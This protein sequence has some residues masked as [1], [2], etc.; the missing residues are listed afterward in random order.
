MDPSKQATGNSRHR[1]LRKVLRRY[2]LDQRAL[3]RLR[4]NSK[5]DLTRP[6]NRCLD[7][8]AVWRQPT[9]A[10]H[11]LIE[12]VGDGASQ[13]NFRPLGR[14]AR[15]ETAAKPNFV[16]LRADRLVSSGA[17]GAGCGLESLLLLRAKMFAVVVRLSVRG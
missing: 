8:R 5:L 3:A 10:P 12:G 16:L 11:C 14:L 7:I 1:S 2:R 15:H 9:A 17:V 6:R 13:L 4:A